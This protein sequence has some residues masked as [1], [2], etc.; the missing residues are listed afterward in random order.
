MVFARKYRP[1]ALDEVIGQPTVVQTLKNALAHKKLHHAY[2]FVGNLGSGKTS[3]SRI[4]AASENCKVSPGHHPCGKCDLCKSVFAG[5]HADILEI[6]AASSAGKV[7]QIRELKQSASFTPIDGAKTKY[8]IIDECL[9]AGALISMA[10][11]SKISIGELV[12]EGLRGQRSGDEVCSRDMNAGKIVH[13]S[14]CRY[15]KIP[16]DKQM[17]KISI[18]DPDGDIRTVKITGNHNVFVKNEGKIK[19]QDLQVGQKIFLIRNR[20][21]KDIDFM[22]AA[23]RYGSEHATD[24]STQNGAVLVNPLTKEIISY[25]ANRFPTSVNESDERWERPL[26]YS[27]VEH[28]ERDAIYNAARRGVSTEGSHMY[29]YWAA[30]ADCARAII[31]VGVARLI[32]HKIIMDATPDRW[33]DTI[34]VAFQMLEEAG[35]EIDEVTESIDDVQIRF[36]GKLWTPVA[37]CCV[38]PQGVL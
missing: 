3:V 18:R 6:D 24:P 33:K 38:S 19:A 8:F 30:C 21:M 2:L 14:I 22:V 23:Y 13:Q 20:K 12:E 17:Y 10:D 27:Y 34:K 32:T 31:Q 35:V 1:K 26:K 29:C 5:T 7:D 25:G 36:N 28:A 11:G 37:E 15:I 16:N 4:L 9:P